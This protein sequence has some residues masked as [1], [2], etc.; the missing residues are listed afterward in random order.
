MTIDLGILVSRH[1]IEV[2]IDGQGADAHVNGLV[3]SDKIWTRW[4][5]LKH[6]TQSRAYDFEQLFKGILAGESHGAFTGKIGNLQET[7]N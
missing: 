5:F 2:S 4:Y 7:L 6:Q 1:N 3:R